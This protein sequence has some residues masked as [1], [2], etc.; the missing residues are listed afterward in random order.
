MGHVEEAG[1]QVDSVRLAHWTTISVITTL[2]YQ[3]QEEEHQALFF[4]VGVHTQ[5]C[6][7]KSGPVGHVGQHWQ[8]AEARPTHGSSLFE[9]SPSMEDDSQSP[10]V[11][12][13]LVLPQSLHVELRKLGLDLG[14][15]PSATLVQ[16]IVMLLRFH[17]RGFGLP[18]PVSPCPPRSYQLDQENLTYPR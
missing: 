6:P 8:R 7:P 9:P 14:L 18:A 5:L 1:F 13:R 16:A 10:V 11:T 15:S 2:I 4:S 17:E 3:Y 12:I